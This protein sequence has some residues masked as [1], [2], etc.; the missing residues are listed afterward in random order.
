M[1]RIAIFAALHWECRPVL[2][3]L[4]QVARQRVGGF[5]AWHG[6][7]RCCEVVLVK[8]GMGITQAAAAAQTIRD[9][10]DG[11]LFVSTGCAGALAAELMPGDVVLATTVVRGDSAGAF[12]TDPEQRE[13]AQRAAAREVLRVVSGPVLCSPEAL[14]TAEHK[15]AAAAR[16]GAVAVEMEGTAVA[17]EAARRGIPFIS[18]RA[19]LDTADTELQHAGKFIEPQTGA[20]RPLAL[21]GYVATHPS[22]IAELVAMQRMMRA[23]QASLERFFGAWFH[24]LDS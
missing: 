10:S 17:R 18:V 13:R 11:A 8:T 23:A 9:S 15:R 1:D 24:T 4:R 14:M 6:A 21:A 2:R 19:I 16:Y 7:T 5:T 22:V 12:V 20:V 3:H